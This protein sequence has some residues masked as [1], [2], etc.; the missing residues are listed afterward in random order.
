MTQLNSVGFVLT[1]MFLLRQ[2]QYSLIKLDFFKLIQITLMMTDQIICG[3]VSSDVLLVLWWQIRQKTIFCGK[4]FILIC[5]SFVLW[6][7]FCC[8][9]TSISWLGNVSNV[10]YPLRCE[11]RRLPLFR[12]CNNVFKRPSFSAKDKECSERL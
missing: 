3:W 10:W 1:A 2:M 9:F 8:F 7:W 5:C 12:Y 11:T 4:F 6:C